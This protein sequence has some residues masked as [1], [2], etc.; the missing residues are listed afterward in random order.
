MI[1]QFRQYLQ[2]KCYYLPDQRVLVGVSGGPDSLCLLH[3]LWKLGFPLAVAHLD[4]NLRPESSAD[5][6]Y[7]GEIAASMQIPFYTSREDI[8]A[9]ANQHMLSIE[10][11]ARVVRYRFL[12]EQATRCQAQAVAVGHTADDQVE[13]VLMHLLRGS[14]IA[15]LKGMVAY[16]LPNPWSQEIPL[17]RPLLATWR[18]EIETY[19]CSTDLQPLQDASNRDTH[20]FRNRLRHE[21]V[22]FLEQYNPNLRRLAWQMADT[23]AEEDRVLLDWAQAAWDSCLVGQGENWLAINS[24][25]LSGQALALQRRLVRRAVHQLRP[26]LRDL[27]YAAVGRAIDAINTSGACDLV[28]GLRLWRDDSL[29]WIAT[30]EAEIPALGLDGQLWPQLPS[31]N[32]IDL[33]LPGAIDLD[34]GWRLTAE[35]VAATPEIITAALS[36]QDP[37]QANLDADLLFTTGAALELRTRRP[38]DRFQPLGLEGHSLKLSDFFINRKL[39]HRAR[40]RWPL[41]VCGET[42]A[43]IPGLQLAHNFRLHEDSTR[44]VHLQLA[45]TS[46]Q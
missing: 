22:P 40:D 39:P 26:G 9:Y 27:D 29:V 10:E 25:E 30:W 36:N 15:G 18:Q 11:A 41:L 34:G 2:E 38:G 42:I 28:G 35:L 21:L 4:H 33:P 1:E 44:I 46:P 16:S 31:R 20:F 24:S 32:A 43:W 3:L 8:G 13:T 6:Q 7:V 23:L 45:R 12:F 5:A 14:G 17:I 37:Y 19:L